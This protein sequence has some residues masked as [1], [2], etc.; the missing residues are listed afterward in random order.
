MPTR[1]LVLSTPNNY[2]PVKKGSK[3]I[4]FLY[5]RNDI[6]TDVYF[7]LYYAL[8]RFN[9]DGT[10]ELSYGLYFEASTQLKNRDDV[11]ALYRAAVRNEKNL[12]QLVRQSDSAGSVV[13]SNES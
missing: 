8:G 7:P 1:S 13:T 6:A 3:Y 10:D 2:R 4:L 5:K 9:V 11:M 12:D